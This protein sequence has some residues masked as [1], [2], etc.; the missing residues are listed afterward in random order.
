MAVVGQIHER[1]RQIK[2]SA[3]KACTLNEW[4]LNDDAENEW[5]S[6]QWIGRIYWIMIIITFSD[7][8]LQ[9]INISEN[10]SKYIFPRRRSITPEVG[11]EALGFAR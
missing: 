6:Y 8:I 3:G 1:L 5:L 11:G 10:F 2:R 9:Y 7:I 4:L